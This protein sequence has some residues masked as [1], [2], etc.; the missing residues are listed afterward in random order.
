MKI[1]Q[2]FAELVKCANAGLP[3]FLQAGPGV[4][5]T[6]IAVQLADH[7]GLPYKEVRCAE[8]ESVDFRGIPV[9]ADGKTKWLIPDFWPTEACVL[10]FDEIS[11][12]RP[13]IVSPLLKIILG[14]QIG[15]Y[16]LPEGTV[17]IATGNRPEDMAGATRLVS[18]LRDRFVVITIEPDL[19]S[20]L[21]W[22]Q[23]SAT[24]SSRVE[25]F[26]KQNPE[27]LYSFEPKLN[28]NQPSPRN[29]DRIGRL[30]PASPARETMAGIIGAKMSEVF[31][32]WCMANV[33]MPTV[34]QVIDGRAA[35]PTSATL[36]T[37][38]A[39]ELGNALNASDDP[40]RTDAIIQQ[41][42]RLAG[43][44]QVLFLKTVTKRKDKKL[45]RLPAVLA[46]V[47]K[48]ASAIVS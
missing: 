23:T 24:F 33:E 12:A 39:N 43:G 14:G 48:H 5:K 30:L 8:F 2:A 9:A 41:V 47:A 44:Y 19:D 35:A 16:T 7:L 27:A 13:D 32:R 26:L 3:V 15:D 21:A 29:W 6:S 25:G 34:Q 36:L 20:F 38:W 10:N 40:A 46:M 17:I 31:S 28:E 11:Q 45:L 18:A 1:N 22:Y 42:E 37:R 4:G